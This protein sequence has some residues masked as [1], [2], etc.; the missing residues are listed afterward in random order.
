MAPQR[1]KRK[2]T[3]CEQQ[4]F[5]AQWMHVIICNSL[6]RKYTDNSLQSVLSRQYKYRILLK[7]IRDLYR[8]SMFSEAAGMLSD[9]F[10]HFPL[11]NILL[12]YWK[13]LE[14]QENSS[15]SVKYRLL[16]WNFLFKNREGSRMWIRGNK[17]GNNWLKVSQEPHTEQLTLKNSS[18]KIHTL[19]RCNKL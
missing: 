4:G 18:V 7:Q 2:L 17:E 13:T 12:R 19:G 11:I 3:A 14:F 15:H 6:Y 8:T 5:L 16:T 10:K 9:W 1:E